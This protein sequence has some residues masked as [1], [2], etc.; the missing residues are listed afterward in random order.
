MTTV[1]L[2]YRLHFVPKT[3]I[4]RMVNDFFPNQADIR[5]TDN[6]F[7]IYS[8]AV[9]KFNFPKNPHVRQLVCCSVFLDIHGG[10]YIHSNLQGVH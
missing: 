3:D 7:F 1:R 10:K 5:R 9:G 8:F 2:T 6:S 4:H